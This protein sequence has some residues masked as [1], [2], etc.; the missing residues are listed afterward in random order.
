MTIARDDLTDSKKI[1]SAKTFD[2]YCKTWDQF[3]STM[4]SFKKE[5][6]LRKCTEFCY[7]GCW[8]LYVDLG[9][10]RAKPCYGQM[11]NQNIFENPENEII[12]EPVG[13][14]CRQPY[15]YNG[16]AYL[17][18]GMIPELD[19]PTYADIR[20]RICEDSS[21]WEQADLKEAFSTK[22]Y[23]T[24]EV[25]DDKKKQL[26][27]RKYLL[28]TIKTAIYDLPEL[29]EKLKKAIVRK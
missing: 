5:L 9:T 6:F 16:H 22:L 2:E 28:R 18:L 12:F 26:Y 25:W 7:A 4:F 13:K 21:E 11:Y 3:D 24:N 27:E 17:A 15:C 10:G 29:K 1:L 20:N 23:D 14:H 19:T 8:S